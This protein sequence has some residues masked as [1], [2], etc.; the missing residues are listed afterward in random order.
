MT[1]ASARGH[2]TLLRFTAVDDPPLAV[3]VIYD[4]DKKCGH[5][6]D[7]G[8]YQHPTGVIMGQCPDLQ[9]YAKNDAWRAIRRRTE[10][11]QAPKESNRETH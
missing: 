5:G 11:M 4:R 6:S 8:N 2:A 3:S 9:H 7:H 1:V 10:P